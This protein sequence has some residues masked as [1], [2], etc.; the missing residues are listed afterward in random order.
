MI[1]AAGIS[2]LNL[3]TPEEHN[4]SFP[5]LQSRS[6]RDSR[7]PGPHPTRTTLLT[8][9]VPEQAQPESADEK[10]RNEPTP[11]LPP[12]REKSINTF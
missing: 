9:A 4:A 1:I 12:Q 5:R 10:S 2:V 3:P 11:P 7:K 6:C 8:V